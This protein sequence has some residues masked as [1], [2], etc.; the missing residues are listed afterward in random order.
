MPLGRIFIIYLTYYMYNEI[1]HD[2]KEIRR[3]IH[4]KLAYSLH[5]LFW[6]IISMGIC[7]NLSF[8]NN[9]ALVYYWQSR[10]TLLM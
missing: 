8:P 5:H 7:P 3:E 4:L 1:D 6:W 9:I 10:N 2:I